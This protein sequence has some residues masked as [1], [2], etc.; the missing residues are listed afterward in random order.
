MKTKKLLILLMIC[1]MVLGI[2]SCGKSKKKR[3]VIDA[4]K[5]KFS[6]T[7]YLVGLMGHMQVTH[8][9]SSVS[10]TFVFKDNATFGPYDLI[11]QDNKA[12][13]SA[14]ISEFVTGVK[15]SYLLFSDD[16]KTVWANMETLDASKF[17]TSLPI[18]TA[19]QRIFAK[20]IT[21]K[22]QVKAWDDFKNGNFNNAVK[23]FTEHSEY[24]PDDPFVLIGLM[25]CYLVKEQLKKAGKTLEN[26][27]ALPAEI[28]NDDF[29]KYAV[30]TAENNYRATV[31]MI[32]DKNAFSDLM[33]A[34]EVLP[35]TIAQADPG[36]I[37]V[38][39]GKQSVGY[40]LKR[41]IGEYC[42]PFAKS[43][44]TF[45]QAATKEDF[46]YFDVFGIMP[47]GDRSI[48]LGNLYLLKGKIAE[49][50]E[51]LDR[52]FEVYENLIIIGNHLLQYNAHTKFI[53]IEY[54]RLGTDALEKLLNE[55]LDSER[56]VKVF[57]EKIHQLV[58]RDEPLEFGEFVKHNSPLGKTAD[59]DFAWTKTHYLRIRLKLLEISTAAKLKFLRTKRYP[60]RDDELIP[61]FLSS[62]PIDPFTGDQIRYYV[63]GAR[64]IAYSLGPDLLDQQGLIIYD[65]TNGATSLGDIVAFQE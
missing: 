59:F 54:R 11:V 6:G 23:T 64:F 27:L 17:G 15:E 55:K 62:I 4:G 44:I 38:I 40:R 35:E 21:E 56:K 47:S 33:T 31:S 63:H 41:K 14:D 29:V 60:R 26:L 30:F 32:D 22:E 16:S 61:D 20:K 43:L 1:T 58:Q 7:Y 51:N 10:V 34:L 9:G 36:I 53:G 42:I 8:I 50:D 3:E 2:A 39:K 48:T 46:I 28:L 49:F 19:T 24:Y 65:P 13:L 45:E 57:I 37:E 12:N 25:N 52:A 5:R 18:I